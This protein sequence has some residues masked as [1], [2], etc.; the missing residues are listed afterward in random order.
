[1][2]LFINTPL[3]YLCDEKLDPDRMAICP[4][5]EVRRAKRSRSKGQEGEG[6]GREN[7]QN[8]KYLKTD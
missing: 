3:L 1:M 2:I 6:V 5:M 8:N 7:C 4:S